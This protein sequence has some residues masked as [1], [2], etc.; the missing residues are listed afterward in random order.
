MTLRRTTLALLILYALLTTFSILG[1][2][3][4]IVS[5]RITTPLATALRIVAAALVSGSD[6]LVSSDS[7][8]C[9]PGL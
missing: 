6:G 4:E 8:Q 7:S 2:A 3:L 9:Y 1:S 5:S